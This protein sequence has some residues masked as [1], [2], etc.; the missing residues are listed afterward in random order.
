MLQNTNEL[1]SMFEIFK[2]MTPITKEEKQDMKR[3]KVLHKKLMS[4][5]E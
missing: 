4:E 2:D 5:N 1:D 3:V